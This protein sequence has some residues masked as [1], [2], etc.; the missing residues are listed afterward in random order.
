[1]L[2]TN[3]SKAYL[4]AFLTKLKSEFSMKDMGKVHYFL[5]IQL[6]HTEKGI[7]L[8]QKRVAETILQRANML[9]CQPLATPMAAQLAVPNG[10]EKFEIGTH[11]RA[12][13]GSLQYLQFTRPDLAYAANSVCQ[14]MHKPTDYH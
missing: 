13:V 10:S 6:L 1:M 4:D 7:F 8:S 9:D 11:Y 2:V 3:C 12:I 5:D 14:Y